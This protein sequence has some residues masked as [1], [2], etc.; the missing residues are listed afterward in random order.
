MHLSYPKL[1]P[2]GRK[3]HHSILINSLPMK[4]IIILAKIYKAIAGIG[5][6]LIGNK[7]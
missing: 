1:Y 3:F 5:E 4:D 6:F 2:I 7:V